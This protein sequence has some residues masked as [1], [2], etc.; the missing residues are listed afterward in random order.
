MSTEPPSA[1]SDTVDVQSNRRCLT[2]TADGVVRDL[3][4]ADLAEIDRIR[5]TRHALVW[6]DIANPTGLDLTLLEDEFEIHPLATEDLRKRRQRPKVDIYG[7]QTVIVAYEAVSFRDGPQSFELAEHHL[8]AGNGYVV[9]VHW[10]ESPMVESVRARF[11]QRAAAIG[12]SAGWLVY[13]LLDAVA[14]TYFPLL[15]Q[16]AEYI[17]DLEE[18]IVGAR[19][20]RSALR[21]ALALKR[22][23][24]ELRR[25][26]GPMRDVANA[27]LRRDNDLIEVEAVPYFQDLYDH[28]VRVLDQVDLYRDLVAS[29]LEANLAVTSNSLNAI[30]KRLTAFTVLLMVPTLIAGIYGMNFRF[31]PELG[32]QWG[33]PAVLL[34]MVVSVAALGLYFRRNGWF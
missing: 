24:L 15:D 22:E 3:A 7:D 32:Q 21:E 4:E 5:K 14:D 26:L 25:V 18:R 30:M 11:R 28:L 19:G 31:M 10:A 16:M 13:A 8:F 29:T 20:G 23:L 34:I 1:G 33:Y 27:M 12:A 6:L 2:L 9:S 17:D